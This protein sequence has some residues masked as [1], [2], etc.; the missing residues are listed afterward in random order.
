MKSLVSVIIPTYNSAQYITEALDSVFKQ[1]HKNMEVIVIDD[2]SSDNTEEVLKD[3]ADRITYIKKEN[4]GPASARNK[5]LEIAKG[6]FIAFLDADD[7]W[8]KDKLKW[9]LKAMDK[10]TGLVGVSNDEDASLEGEPE[11]VSFEDMVVKNRF[12][13]SSILIK[14][15]C[16]KKLGVFDEREEFKAVEDW[17]LWMR[18]IKEYDGI[19][20]NKKIVEIRPTENSISAPSQAGKMLNN[21]KAVLDKNLNGSDD[22]KVLK[23]KALGYRYFCAAWAYYV[24]K[25][26]NKA[27]SHMVKSLSYDPFSLLNK[28]QGGLL[29][30]IVINKV[31]RF[32]MP[33]NDLTKPLFGLMYNLHVFLR[34][35]I[36][37]VLKLFY[38]EPLFCSQCRKV[39]KNLWME[40]LPYIVGKGNIDIGDEVRLSGKSTFTISNKI[41]DRPTI[42]IGNHTFIG[43][44]CK[45]ICAQNIE[46]GEHCHLAGAVTIADND[47]H[48]IE[49]NERRENK[50]PKKSNVK[51]VKIGNDAW[52]GRGAVIL[53]GVTIG[54]RSIVGAKC[55]VSKDVPDDCIVVGNP[56]KIVQR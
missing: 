23:K 41:N 45:F 54:E 32:R 42:S 6:D 43:H 53:K 40:Q 8:L 28:K 19:L 46:I 34:E 10:E 55:V 47:G 12:C 17:D 50:P 36:A 56:A 20:L 14:R 26:T 3:Y 35:T 31:I 21:E 2:G 11:G 48:P 1:T 16:V 9:Q 37:F 25:D 51:D 29:A 49:F 18:I 44:D 24:S 39:G 15:E 13:N 5:G 52:I 27:F 22:F 38:F 33:V 30:K 4:G 7:L